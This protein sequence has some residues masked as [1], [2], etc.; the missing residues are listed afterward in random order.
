MLTRSLPALL[1]LSPIVSIS[2]NCVA[3][4]SGLTFVA[5]ALLCGSGCSTKGRPLPDIADEINS[6]FSA[7][8]AISR[9]APGDT[10]E[11][12][13]DDPTKNYSTTVRE[14]GRASFSLLDDLQVAGLD[15]TALDAFV[16]EAYRLKEQPRELTVVRLAR[17]RTVAIFGEVRSPG[18][19]PVEDG[20]YLL[21]CIAAAGSFI[22]E[23]ANLGNVILLRWLPSEQRQ[24]AWSIDARERYWLEAPPIRL[25]PDDIVYIPNT[26]IDEIDIWVDQYIRRLIPLPSLIPAA[27]AT[28]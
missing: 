6:T 18:K 20:L 4:L 3:K 19:I 2:T 13:F 22:K 21:E 14:D 1:S 9:V 17:L 11:V 8:S 26:A 10:L 12:R 16:T 28:F 15:L 23:T 5:L 27:P 24:L 7:I 25:Q